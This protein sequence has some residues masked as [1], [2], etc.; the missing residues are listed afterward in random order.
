MSPL[1][2]TSTPASS[3]APILMSPDAHTRRVSST[4]S[5]T[6]WLLSKVRG[7]GGPVAEMRSGVVEAS[8]DPEWHHTMLLDN[9]AVATARGATGVLVRARM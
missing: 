1:S 2:R 3:S 8:S 4:S 6:A 5:T 9:L 7:S